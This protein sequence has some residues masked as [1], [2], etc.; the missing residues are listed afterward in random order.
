[1]LPYIYYLTKSYNIND[2]SYKCKILF[3]FY[4]CSR[5][6][7]HV[8]FE[9]HQCDSIKQKSIIGFTW[10]MIKMSFDRLHSF[11]MYIQTLVRSR[12]GTIQYIKF[13]EYYRV[14]N[15]K[16]PA[17]LPLGLDFYYKKYITLQINYVYKKY[18]LKES[19]HMVLEC[20]Q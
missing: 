20:K 7:T 1:M 13:S 4:V 6:N 8:I 10:S 12:L 9:L 19:M 14:S 11:C 15:P 17:K 18:R 5:I 16:H 3:T 2:I